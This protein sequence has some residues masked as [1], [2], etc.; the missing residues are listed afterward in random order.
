M[1]IKHSRRLKKML[2]VGLDL[3]FALFRA[4]PCFAA[5]T[6]DA[7]R[8]NDASDGWQETVWSTSSCALRPYKPNLAL[9]C[10]PRILTF[11]I[12]R[13]KNTLSKLE[14]QTFIHHSLTFRMYTP[15]FCRQTGTW[16]GQQTHERMQTRGCAL[17][18]ANH[19]EALRQ[20]DPQGRHLSALRVASDARAWKR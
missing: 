17:D 19:L 16:D 4:D 18:S 10:D 9:W 8:S 11:K 5:V 12:S 3:W 15:L 13:A 20:V 6:H 2:G 7:S 14:T 1:A